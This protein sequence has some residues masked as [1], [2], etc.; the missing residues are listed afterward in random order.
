LKIKIFITIFSVIISLLIACDPLS[1]D[2]DRDE[3]V[4]PNP[5]DSLG[6]FSLDIQEI[7]FG[8]IDINEK[9]TRYI[10][11]INNTNA[12]IRID[13]IR[14]S[15]SPSPYKVT[16]ISV[17]FNLN[18]KDKFGSERSLQVDCL[19]SFSGTFSDELTISGDQ[20]KLINLKS[21]VPL[22]KV[23][24]I[25]F[26]DF[27]DDEYKLKHL[28]IENRSNSMIKVDSL[29]LFDE[30]SVFMLVALDTKISEDFVIMPNKYLQLSM[31]FKP[32]ENII[33]KAQIK[34]FCD[35]CPEPS[36][37][38]ADIEANISY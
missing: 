30:N 23:S 34:V 38:T 22:V 8:L 14:F 19:Q 15:K 9:K 11:I 27:T 20:D 36:D 24:D 5:T 13:D 32:K 35:N 4:V 1:V 28:F 12:R 21:A 33:Y 18:P 6:Y 29:Q 3:T 25:N 31:L 16:G 10:K 2:A 37:L 7:N 17:P 26:S